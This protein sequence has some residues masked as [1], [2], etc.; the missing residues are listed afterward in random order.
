MIKVIHRDIKPENIFRVQNKKT[1]EIRIGDF[2]VSKQLE[3]QVD[4]CKTNIGTPYYLAPEIIKK[5]HYKSGVDIWS[6][7]VMMY[8]LVTFRYPFPAN[9]M[10]DLMDML[11]SDRAPDPF[12]TSNKIS[13]DLRN[14]ILKMLNKDPK[15]RP[16]IE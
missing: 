7:G 3:N 16:S 9:S 2:G 6:L 12:T 11:K 5:E 8:E 13:E 10:W 1:L 4:I 14:L 15:I